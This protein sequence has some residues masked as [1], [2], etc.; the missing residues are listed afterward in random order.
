MEITV[1]LDDWSLIPGPEKNPPP[2]SVA[3]EETVEISPD[4]F[5][6]TVLSFPGFEQVAEPDPD[7]WAW[8]ASR[9]DMTIE[10]TLFET[11]PVT[12]G[13]SFLKGTCQLNKF[14]EFW[15]HLRTLSPGIWLHNSACEVLTPDMF[16]ERTLSQ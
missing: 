2:S 5:A 4:R 12:W 13:G 16:L 14:L 8:K 15:D 3:I 9:H 7:W 1:E 10:M 11:E 6:A